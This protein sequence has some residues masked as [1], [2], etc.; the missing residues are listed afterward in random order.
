MIFHAQHCAYEAMYAS[1]EDMEKGEIL[2][3]LKSPAF[4]LVPRCE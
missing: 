3:K 1:Y 4:L 2:W